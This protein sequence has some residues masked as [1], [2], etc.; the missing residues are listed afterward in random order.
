MSWCWSGAFF[1]AL[2]SCSWKKDIKQKNSK[3]SVK[4]IFLFLEVSQNWFSSVLFCF[5]SFPSPWLQHNSLPKPKPWVPNPAGK[6]MLQGTFA[7]A[8]PQE[9]IS[10]GSR[11][12]AQQVEARG[13]QTHL[14]WSLA[15]LVLE[16]DLPVIHV[17]LSTVVHGQHNGSGQQRSWWATAHHW[18]Q[19]RLAVFYRWSAMK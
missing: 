4:S 1:S 11:H 2:L 10:W 8:L 9:C 5:T 3:Y 7:P 13:L 19:Q 15:C 18:C 14:P 6:T 12:L 16:L 17:G